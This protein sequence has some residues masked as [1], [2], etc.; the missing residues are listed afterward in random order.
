MKDKIIIATSKDITGES[1][2]FNEKTKV[3]FNMYD[4]FSLSEILYKLYNEKN[5]FPFWNIENLE[6]AIKLIY[7]V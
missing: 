7:E 2:C 5:N 6:K 4:E 3:F 1:I